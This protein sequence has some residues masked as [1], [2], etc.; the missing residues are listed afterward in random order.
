MRTG[1][2]MVTDWRRTCRILFEYDDPEEQLI[3]FD[4]I[5]MSERHNV[6]IHEKH[7]TSNSKNSTQQFL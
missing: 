5:Q 4:I 6:E 7:N 3:A 1:N 2:K